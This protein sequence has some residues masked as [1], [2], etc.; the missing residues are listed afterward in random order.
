MMN[1]IL[2]RFLFA[3]LL[4]VRA[5]ALGITADIHV[6]LTREHQQ[7]VGGGAAF[8]GAT[9]YL[10]NNRL[11]ATQRQ[12]LMRF[13]F[14]SYD[15]FGGAQFNAMRIVMGSCDFSLRNYTYDDLPDDV[16]DDFDLQYFS[17][18]NELEYTVPMVREALQVN[19][20]LRIIA[21]PWSAPAWMKVP[22]TLFGGLLS[23]NTNVRRT[24][25]QYFRK[26]VEAYINVGIPLFAVTVQN[27]PRFQTPNY[28]SMQLSPEDEVQMALLIAEEFANSTI[29]NNTTKVIVYDHNWDDPSYPIQVME[30]DEV[31]QNPTIVGSAF[32]CYAGNVAAQ[33]LVHAAVPSKRM[34]FTECTGGSWAPQFAGN[35]MWD[36]SNLI[37]GSV[38]LWAES[39]TKW[40]MALDASGGPH[41]PNACSDCRGL[42]TID[43]AGAISFNE[44]FY[45]LAHLSMWLNASERNVRVSAS[46]TSSALAIKTPSSVVVV[47]QNSDELETTFNVTFSGANT[48]C[49]GTFLLPTQ[50]IATIRWRFAS[51][52][53]DW[54][55]TSGDKTQL[56]APQRPR[57]VRCMPSH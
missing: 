42:L 46:N 4:T 49:V 53:A 36:T 14:G 35:L 45:P 16:A 20:H 12:D 30:D 17:I 25:A 2:V 37:I 24:Y 41:L 19:P 8:S 9:T 7:V 52:D 47:L 28:P 40:N 44:D 55:L 23:N 22:S 51:A 18:E 33:G 15:E 29:I 56:R 3:V 10:L 57:D 43:D 48:T 38:N 39:V 54:V 6:D 27:E 5:D 26:F 32:H 13:L 50:S 34:F 11:N 31:L 21:S 1:I